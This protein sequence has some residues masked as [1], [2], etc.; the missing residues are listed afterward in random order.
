MQ[1]LRVQFSKL[2]PLRFLSHLDLLRLWERAVRRA[3]LPLAYSEGFSPHPRISLALP[4][5]V[6]ITSEAEIAEV[7]LDRWIALQAF[8]IKLSPQMPEG[9]KLGEVLPLPSEAP[10]LPSQVTAAEYRVTGHGSRPEITDAIKRLLSASAIPWSH[11]RGAESR[12]YDL[13]PLINDLWLEDNCGPPVIAMRLRAD[14]GGSG[15]PDQ[16]YRALGFS[17]VPDDIHRTRI[18]LKS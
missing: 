10:P 5:P 14:P 16:V 15:R 13:R 18:I 9:L 17:G 1:R 4:L 12:S 11:L 2:E 3:G 7:N 8:L 6:G